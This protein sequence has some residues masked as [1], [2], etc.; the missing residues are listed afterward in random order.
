MPALPD[1]AALYAEIGRDFRRRMIGVYLTVGV[2]ALLSLGLFNSVSM[3]HGDGDFTAVDARI[4][5]VGKDPRS[6]RLTMTS[7]FTD[8]TGKVHRD[9]QDDGYHYASGDPEVG[10]RIEYLYEFDA[11]YGDFHA[12][13]RADRILQWV[14]GAPAALLLLV[15]GGGLVFLLRKRA[16]RRRMVRG[17]RREPAQAVSIRERTVVLPS[18]NGVQVLPMWRLEASYFEPSRSAFVACHSEWQHSPTTPQAGDL[19]APVILVDPERPG[20]YWLPVAIPAG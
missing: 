18:G 5:A 20:R 2:A 8:A 3:M 11:Y 16:W 17:G 13:P 9:T 14:F 12:F 10:Q 1:D 7:E 15:G 19:P 4:V 6:G